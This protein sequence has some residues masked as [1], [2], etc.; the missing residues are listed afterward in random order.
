MTNHMKI[1]TNENFPLYGIK[2]RKSRGCM[3]YLTFQS[4]C[5]PCSST[6]HNCCSSMSAFN[7]CRCLAFAVLALFLLPSVAGAPSM[8]LST[9]T[10]DFLCI[11]SSLA[12]QSLI[13]ADSGVMMS[14]FTRSSHKC[15]LPMAL[16]FLYTDY[17]KLLPTV[18]S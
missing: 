2:N 16:R 12:R 5:S 17:W 10:S 8:T 9:S 11:W 15:S 3:V 1:Y 14:S 7:L 6:S 18:K 4:R 13:I